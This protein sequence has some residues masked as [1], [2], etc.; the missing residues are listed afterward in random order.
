MTGKLCLD[1]NHLPQMASH[2]PDVMLCSTG[3]FRTTIAKTDRNS[4]A[5][6]RRDQRSSKRMWR[7]RPLD[8]SVQAPWGDGDPAD[9]DADA[10]GDV[11][12]GRHRSIIAADGGHDL[13]EFGDPHPVTVPCGFDLDGEAVIR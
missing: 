11:L 9:R 12:A 6:A 2:H 3:I 8:L 7:E 1:I 4:C 5:D 10:H 13:I